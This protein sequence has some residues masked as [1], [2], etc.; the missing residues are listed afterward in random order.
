MSERG[1]E[2]FL[3][4]EGR[5]RAR[6]IRTRLIWAR[7]LW[8][9]GKRGAWR[10]LSGLLHSPLFIV[11][12]L[13]LRNTHALFEPSPK[14]ARAPHPP[15]VRC[16]PFFFLNYHRYFLS[17]CVCLC[18]R[19]AAPPKVSIINTGGARMGGGGIA[20]AAGWGRKPQRRGVPSLFC[21]PPK[22]KWFFKEYELW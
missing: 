17:L 7:E 14:L 19:A 4:A 18:V 6:R 1:V 9:F 8:S 3:F 15:Q 16:P 21:F 22:N 5:W 10:R 20:A 2:L 11:S 12:P 13:C